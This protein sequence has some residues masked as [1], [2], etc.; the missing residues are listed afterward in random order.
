ML[1]AALALASRGM[2][3]CPCMPRDKRPATPHG[4]KDA[5]TDVIAIQTWWQENASYNI[6]IACGAASNV[7]VVDVDGGT[8]ETALKRLEALH[9]ELPPT[10]EAITPNGRHVYLRYPPVSVR[11]SAG[12]LADNIDI[13]AEGGFVIAPPSVHPSGRRYA[14]SVDSANAFAE[15]PRWLLDKI[16]EPPNSNSN[17]NSNSNGNGAIPASEWRGLVDNGVVEGQR[18]TQITRLTGHLLRRYVDPHVTHQLVQAWNATHCRPPLSPEDV[19][20]IVN[21]IAGRELKRRA[22]GNGR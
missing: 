2:H 6:G 1:A 13:R 10:V 9:S 15:A 22:N 7:F 19:T 12:K 5:T 8:A 18:N 21:S 4:C 3:V 14:W 16:A 20:C 11:N 17:S